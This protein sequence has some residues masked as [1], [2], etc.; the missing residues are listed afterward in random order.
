MFWNAFDIHVL[1]DLNR[2]LQKSLISGLYVLLF[3]L[4]S[5]SLVCSDA[6]A[7]GMDISSVKYVVSYE[8]P[9]HIQTYIHRIGRTARAG[10]QGTAFTL[11]QNKEVPLVF[12]ALL[13][14][15][16]PHYNNIAYSLSKKLWN[17]W[18]NGLMLVFTEYW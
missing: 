2:I 18:W 5:N 16:M 9:R 8:P 17:C 14:Y 7:R 15:T 6:M 3:C 12:T 10:Q 11:L 13:L 1:L 4:I